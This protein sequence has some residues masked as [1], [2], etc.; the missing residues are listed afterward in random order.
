MDI[1]MLCASFL[2]LLNQSDQ[3][4]YITGFGQLYFSPGL[5]IW[6]AT[7]YLDVGKK[8]INKKTSR[9]GGGWFFVSNRIFNPPPK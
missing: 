1:F 9:F 3:K 6:A 8:L 4:N 5:W 2:A 7:S